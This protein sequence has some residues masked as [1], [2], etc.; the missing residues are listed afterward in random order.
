MGEVAPEVI[1]VAVR[2]YLRRGL[3][4]RALHDHASDQ[5]SLLS[6]LAW[7]PHPARIANMT[8]NVHPPHKIVGSPVR[9]GLSH[10]LYRCVK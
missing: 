5:S 3:S 2:R 9:P 7:R 1:T 8:T 10:L 6:G 4:Y